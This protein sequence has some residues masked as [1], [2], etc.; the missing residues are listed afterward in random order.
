MRL[1]K[2]IERSAIG[3][4]L[5]GWALVFLSFLFGVSTIFHVAPSTLAQAQ[6]AL[7][8]AENRNNE[9]GPCAPGHSSVLDHCKTTSVCPFCVAIASAGAASPPKATHPFMIVATLAR[10]EINPPHFRPPMLRSWA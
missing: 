3:T 5:R 1:G 4:A 2:D 10:A 8:H 6:S 7:L 9:S